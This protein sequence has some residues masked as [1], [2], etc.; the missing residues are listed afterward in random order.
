MDVLRTAC[1]MLNLQLNNN[2]L[3]VCHRLT[4]LSADEH[5]RLKRSLTA[6][7][8]SQVS[9]ETPRSASSS[10]PRSGSR[11]DVVLSVSKNTSRPNP[12]LVLGYLHKNLYD[13][14]GK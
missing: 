3:S 9:V 4:P 2:W 7:A 5:M 13:T 12:K 11:H 6:G 10:R 14:T 1:K 8:V